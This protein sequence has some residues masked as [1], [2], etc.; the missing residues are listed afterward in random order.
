MKSRD[1]LN[2]L[3]IVLLLM[4]G[5]C[6]SSEPSI[7]Q[8]EEQE[9]QG[10]LKDL[11]QEYYDAVSVRTR[12]DHLSFKILEVETKTYPLRTD[13]KSKVRKIAQNTTEY[14]DIKTVNI[15]FEESVGYAIL[16]DTPGI[17]KVFMLTES[18]CINDTVNNIALREVIGTYPDV[19]RSI[20]TD[21]SLAS[22]ALPDFIIVD[23][24]VRFRWNQDDPFNRY[25]TYCPCDSCQINFGGHK[26]LGCVAT[27]MAQAIATMGS[28]SG[29]FYGARD[30]NFKTIPAYASQMT[31]EEK[32]QV[33]HFCQE[34]ALCCQMK[35]GCD[36]SHA[37]VKAAY[38]Y[39]R[40]LGYSCQYAEGSIDVAKVAARLHS[41][42]PHL[43]TG[44]SNE[45]AHMWI[46]DGIKISND[47]FQLHCNWG[48]G[49]TSDCWTTCASF[50]PIGKSYTFDKN[51]KHI[52]INSKI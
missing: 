52:Y 32:L 43:I 33:A 2:W 4:F 42:F 6:N 14:F 51:F 5:S 40:D 37:S 10:K 44:S 50:K 9:N 20:L 1:T 7:N 21:V 30:L 29:S 12:A 22:R 34:I 41:G 35:F 23:P 8:G 3:I 24:I 25:A 17:D 31:P 16:S 39:L 15:E 19:A 45:G 11:I 28:F 49:G 36:G 38:N 18:G 47:D 46:I 13:T 48:W 27:A 26:P